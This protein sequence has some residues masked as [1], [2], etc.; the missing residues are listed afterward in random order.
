MAA[1]FQARRGK[2]AAGR[3]GAALREAKRPR[4]AR[5]RC[6]SP[7]GGGSRRHSGGARPFTAARRWSNAG[8]RG[9]ERGKGREGRGACGEAHRRLVLR[10]GR[11]ESGTQREGAELD[12][13]LM[14]A[15]VCSFDSGRRRVQSSTRW[16]EEGVG[17]GCAACNARNRGTAARGGRNRHRRGERRA[18]RVA[19]FCCALR[20]TRGRGTGRRKRAR[21]RA[22]KDGSV[23][24]MGEVRRRDAWRPQ[25]RG[26]RGTDHPG[27]HSNRI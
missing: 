17:R 7:R 9:I 11:P 25:R 19:R 2:A 16:S 18:A 14:A 27:R 8:S 5:R 21:L 12:E 22:D 3:G 26:R 13:A 15:A 23:C 6:G 10:G 20:A 1:P 24:T 4:G